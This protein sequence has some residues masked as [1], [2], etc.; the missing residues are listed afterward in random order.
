MTKLHYISEKSQRIVA[1]VLTQFMFARTMD[2]V[3]EVK[4]SSSTSWIGINS[5]D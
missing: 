2:E 3:T 5:L 4:T 1:E